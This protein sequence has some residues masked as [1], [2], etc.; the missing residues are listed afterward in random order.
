MVPASAPRSCAGS[1]G[2]C[3]TRC[4]RSNYRTRMI[5]DLTTNAGNVNYLGTAKSGAMDF[6]HS[7][8]SKDRSPRSPEAQAKYKILTLE[9]DVAQAF[10][11]ELLAKK[12]S[13]ELGASMETQ[14]MGEQIHI[15]A[16]AGLPEAPSF[17][18]RTLFA[19]GGLGAGLYAWDRSYS[20][21]SSQETIPAACFA[22]SNRH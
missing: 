15:L 17:P 19:L 16:A 10:Y 21:A 13:A 14:Q 9:Y 12:S 3:S 8:I 6:A 11:K 1:S 2:E 20:V 18:D 22:F 5:T 4:W 7:V